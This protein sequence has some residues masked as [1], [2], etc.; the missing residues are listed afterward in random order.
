M[1][2]DLVSVVD[3]VDHAI[4]QGELTPHQQAAVVALDRG[5]TLPQRQQLTADWRAQGSPAAARPLAVPYF[6][7]L[8][9]AK[10][11]GGRWQGGRMCFSSTC[12]M[13]AEFMHPG[14]LAGAGQPDDRYLDLVTRFGGTTDANAQ[15]KALGSLGIE[16]RFRRDGSIE[17]IIRQI[18]QR[19]PV[20]VGWLHRGPVSNP[21]IEDS[22]WTLGIGWDP[23]T[24]EVIM[25]DPNGEARLVEGGYVTTAIG[26]GKGVRYSFE[27]WGR[28][29]MAGPTGGPY[30]FTPGTGWW[31]ELSR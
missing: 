11:Q 10:W 5:L 30:R 17:A 21:N 9:S 23:A 27:N 31:L 3:L 25:H 13:V 15:V 12:A 14:C 8:D 18:A 2:E 4:R 16:A 19:L 29:W 20:P 28:R 24:R 26:A 7:Q 1:S 22:H 6:A